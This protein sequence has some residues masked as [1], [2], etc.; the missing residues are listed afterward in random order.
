M[1]SDQVI[2]PVVQPIQF[3]RYSKESSFKF[4]IMQSVPF[5]S[6]HKSVYYIKIFRKK[7][8]LYITAYPSFNL[9][10]KKNPIMA[11]IAATKKDM[12]TPWMI[13]SM[14]PPGIAA[15][16]IMV[17]KTAV[18]IDPETWRNV[19]FTAVPC[20]IRSSG[21]WFNA[22]VVIGIITIAIAII[23]RPFIVAK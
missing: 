20:G 15:V 21:N 17:T 22:K 18:P 10:D 2:L 23:L 16:D 6:I 11:A 3:V 5:N 4:Y 8:S 9:K 13:P 12:F 14:S 1:Y 7:T 19:L